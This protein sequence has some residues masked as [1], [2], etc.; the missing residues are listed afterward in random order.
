MYRAR[1][2]LATTGNYYDGTSYSMAAWNVVLDASEVATL[3]NG[4]NAR[5][6]N[7]QATD[8]AESIVGYWRPGLIGTTD[9]EFGLDYA[10][11]GTP[12]DM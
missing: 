6:L 9:E 10:D 3:Y 12:H 2:G 11:I 8:K 4:G 1:I 5:D 7:V